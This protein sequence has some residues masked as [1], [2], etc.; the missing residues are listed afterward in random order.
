MH[1]NFPFSAVQIIWTLTFAALL[2]LL[3]VLLGRD[4]TSRFPWF[5]GSIVLAGLTHLVS[6]LLF[7]RLPQLTFAAVSIVLA[8]LSAIVGLVVLVEFAHR[9]F[10]RASRR[11]WTIGTVTLLIAGGVVLAEWGTWPS[12]Q[13]LKLANPI[14]VLSLL[15][16]IA[17]KAGILSSVLTIGLGLLIVVLGRRFG[18]GIRSHAQQIMIGL[19]LVALAQV[20]AQVIWQFI[21][22]HTVPHSLEEYQH[23]MAIKDRLINGNSAVYAAV[24]VGWV[25][26]LWFDEPGSAQAPA[27]PATEP[28]ALPQ[29]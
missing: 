20:G 4:R 13:T 22:L 2:V 27:T 16:L 25:L 19:S 7:G 28:P 21:A 10:G 29:A 23:V 6:R 15:Q 5:T 12:V 17:E 14:A 18:S 26:C 8:D 11:A 1:L 9:V 24:V 3:V